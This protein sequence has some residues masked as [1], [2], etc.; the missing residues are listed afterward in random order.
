[1]CSAYHNTSYFFSFHSKIILTLS[2][3]ISMNNQIKKRLFILGL[4]LMSANIVSSQNIFFCETKIITNNNDTLVKSVCDNYFNFLKG[5]KDSVLNINS[6][7]YTKGSV[8]IYAEYKNK[9]YNG[10][11]KLMLGDSLLF[12]QGYMKN[13]KPDSTF[14]CYQISLP[15]YKKNLYKTT[16][17]NNLKNG[18]EDEYN[19]KGTITYVR[20]F[21]NGILNGEYKFYD[22]YGNIITDGWY[23]M[24]L[25]NDTWLEADNERRINIYQNYKNDELINS[26]WTSNYSNGKLFI[27]GM[28][29]K[30]SKKQ[31][32]FKIYNEDGSLK[33]TESYKDG[34]RNG[35]FI[36]YYDGQPISKT[37][38]K[39]D[40]I[41]K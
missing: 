37:R 1:M 2:K 28:Y 16:Y 10:Q 40:M 19:D 7:T 18:E 38:Y 21:T 29:D 5:T 4:L 11:V 24:G 36:E 33:S 20:H 39:N 15:N 32:I 6:K 17:R 8:Y 14:T 27:E 31:G 25:K 30:D 23:K 26:R 3:N 22:D 34:K 35:D 9:N 12:M 41:V 13:G